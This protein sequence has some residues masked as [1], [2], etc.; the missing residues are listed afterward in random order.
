LSEGR[1]IDVVA[2]IVL[3]ESRARVLLALRKP[4]QHQG[5]RWE[6]PGGKLEPGESVDAA[7][8]REL[9][10][11]IGLRPLEWRP[12]TTLEHAYPGKRVRLHF[13]DVTRFDGEPSGRE[14]QTLRWVAIAELG[15]LAFPDANQ[16]V[17]DALVAEASA[18]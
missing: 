7:L 5:G 11:E 13:V 15:A 9:D 6:F 8:A 2:G 16:T 4:R 3:D 17:V 14:G 18:A 10:E 1:T 12:R